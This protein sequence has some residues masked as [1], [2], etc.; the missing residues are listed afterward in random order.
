MVPP[1]KWAQLYMKVL[2]KL[3]LSGGVSLRLSIEAVP[4][5][6]AKEQIV[7]DTKAALRGLGLEDHVTTE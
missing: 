6:G 3:V 1:Q 2:T 4:R 7:E 5:E